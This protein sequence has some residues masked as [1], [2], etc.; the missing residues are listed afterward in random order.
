MRPNEQDVAERRRR[1]VGP[2]MVAGGLRVAAIT[3]PVAE[4]YVSLARLATAHVA[5]TLGLSV[6]RVADLRLAVDEACG[7]FL[8]GT[9]SLIND[10]DVVYVAAD[11]ADAAT[12]IELCFDR[13]PGKLRITVVGPIPLVP[14]VS[15][16]DR[17]S[18]GWLVLDTLVADVRYEIEP[19][20]G[21]GTLTLVEPLS[22]DEASRDALWFA[23]L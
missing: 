13:L 6:G 15:W 12:S 10:D 19:G 1:G 4:A 14:A 9:A 8:H 2:A 16:P 23:A 3:M 18:L 20:D 21:L 11:A 7:Q 22:T 5:G 17:E